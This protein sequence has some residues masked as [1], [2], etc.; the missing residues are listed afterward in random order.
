MTVYRFTPV[1]WDLFRPHDGTPEAGA[2][3]VKTQPAGCPRNGTMGH[4][5][6]KSATTGT[7]HGLV[8][9]NSL[10]R[11]SKRELREEIAKLESQEEL[12]LARAERSYLA[13]TATEYAQGAYEAREALEALEDLI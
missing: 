11:L 8:L 12:C 2:L 1:G 7:F 10:T 13:E 3:V 6:V 9:T 5:F 4:C